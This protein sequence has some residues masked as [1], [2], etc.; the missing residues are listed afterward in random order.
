M[1]KVTLIKASALTI[2]YFNRTFIKGTFPCYSVMWSLYCTDNGNGRAQSL[3]MDGFPSIVQRMAT[4]NRSQRDTAI[5]QAD[6]PVCTV[7]YNRKFL[8]SQVFGS[9]LFTDILKINFQK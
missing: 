1:M 2:K 8:E 5:N 4:A 3:I 7:P 6:E 9:S